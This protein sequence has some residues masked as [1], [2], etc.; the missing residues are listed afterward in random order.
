MKLAVLLIFAS[1]QL[2]AQTSHEIFTSDNFKGVQDQYGKVLIPAVYDEIGWSNGDKSADNQLIGFKE[3]EKWGLMTLNNKRITDSRFDKIE[4]FSSGRYL[5]AV[6]GKFTNRYFYGLIDSKGNIILNLDY[7]EL[8]NDQ[9]VTLVTVYENNHFLMGSINPN[10]TKGV[11]ITYLEIDVFGELLIA[12]KGANHVD[13]YTKSGQIIERHVNN[14]R[15]DS[16]FLIITKQGQKGAISS[17]GKVIHEPKLKEVKSFNRVVPFPTWEIQTD[18]GNFEISCD[19][20]NNLGKDLWIYHANGFSQFFSTSINQPSGSFDFKQQTDGFAIVKSKT[21]GK[22]SAI[23]EFGKLILEA[24]DS[25]HFNG[26]YFYV[27]NEIGWSIYNR[28]GVGI[29][30]KI[31]ETVLPKIGRYQPV[32]KFNYWAVFDCI[33]GTLSDFRYDSI[34]QVIDSKFIA[35]YVGKWGVFHVGH[36]WLIPPK[37]DLI[38]FQNGHFLGTKGRSHQLINY[39]GRLLFQTIDEIKAKD[40]Y[41]V[42]TYAGT[43]SA[44]NKSG[45]P[46][47]NTIY[48]SVQKWEG[49]Y[50]LNL[51][52]VDLVNSTG[53]HIL[54]QRDQIEDIIAFS[55]DLFLIKK[56]NHYGFIDTQGNLRIANRYD[57]ARVF[58]EGLAAIQLRSKW[59]F[60]DKSENIIIQPH[61]EWVSS[62]KNE[63][64]IFKLNG[65][66]GLLNKSGEEV[67]VANYRSISTASSGNYV[68]HSKNGSYAMADPNG[69]T[70]LSGAYENLT[71][72]GNNKVIGTLSEKK[73]VLNYQGQTIV[74]FEY[75]DIQIKSNYILLKK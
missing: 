61:Y 32:R 67:L 43:F 9:G 66:Y 30:K 26:K 8:T 64:A 57:S 46:V 55:E 52:Y 59:G 25:I 19:S 56:N 3:N 4:P 17:A 11:D 54:R 38:N 39:N 47:A 69:I 73:G 20:I 36:G 48:R 58:S 63:L 41:F 35:Q 31:F 10:L 51:Q 50:E 75:E 37:F 40:D 7:F 68:M 49:F 72:L 22:W 71:D 5:V 29:S 65:F 27:K 24:H 44:V 23:S 28:L 70:F 15:K 14:T 34:S 45:R 16:L 62:F 18:A 12:K 74:K 21:S 33:E 2:A 1:W 42:L 13:I 6:K 53:H 60:I